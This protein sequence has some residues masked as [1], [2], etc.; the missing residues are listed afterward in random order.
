MIE[1]TFEEAVRLAKNGAVLFE[2]LEEGEHYIPFTDCDHYCDTIERPPDDYIDDV[3]EKMMNNLGY[4]VNDQ[5][6]EEQHRF[7]M[8]TR[9]GVHVEKKVYKL[10]WR[11]Y[12]FGFVIKMSELKKVIV[13]K[14]LDKA[15]VGSLDSSPYNKNQLLGCVGFCKSKKDRRVLKPCGDW[16]LEKF[17]VQNIT[18]DETILTYDDLDQDVEN[19]SVDIDDGNYNSEGSRFAPPWEIL[20]LLVMNLNVELRCEK[21]RYEPWARIGWAIAGVA[22]AAKRYEDGLG[23]WL[24]FCRQC[25]SAYLEDPMKARLV[26]LNAKKQDHQLG[27]SS[28]MAALREDNSTV[29]DEIRG[30]L[31]SGNTWAITDDNQVGVIR[32]FLR[33]KLSCKPNR[34]SSIFI[35]EYEDRKVIVIDTTETYCSIKE[36]EHSDS[37]FPLTYY[38]IASRN[39]KE[40]CRHPECRDKS[41][42]TVSAENYGEALKKVV[43]DLL[44]GD[45]STEKAIQN[46]LQHTF[47]GDKLLQKMNY[48]IGERVVCDFSLDRF[49]LT[50][51]RYCPIHDCYHE[52]PENCLILSKNIQRM[53]I[54]CRQDAFSYYPP[55]GLLVP[56][57]IVNVINRGIIVHNHF[58]T[59]TDAGIDGLFDDLLPIFKDAELNRLMHLSFKGYASDVAQVFYYLGH[60]RFGVQSGESDTWW[61]WDTEEMRWI[62]S[63]HKANLFCDGEL[64][65]KYQFA[66]SWYK[67]NTPDNDIRIRRLKQVDYLLKRLK[68]RDQHSILVQAAIRTRNV[69]SRTGWTVTK[70][71]SIS[72]GRSSILPGWSSEMCALLIMFRRQQD[73]YCPSTVVNGKQ[74]LWT[75]SGRLCQMLLMSSTC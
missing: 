1:L 15:G 30:K 32:D 29:Y 10:S 37:E 60:C 9:H 57:K 62:Q 35:K 48:E 24:W 13:R 27:W 18:G 42:M 47:K 51:N 2:V 46:L 40:K 28:L 65:G 41:G 70:T 25:M 33:T 8:A 64:A 59:G 17:M 56:P 7:G 72:G 73:T 68:D 19:D 75:L 12:F 52:H 11:C 44:S 55:D 36:D 16:P 58:T 22:R 45:I 5:F 3:K 31:A 69:N 66:A 63:S 54:K 21:G 14:R 34:I 61:A 67:N 23:L 20:E 4:L 38:I 50:E 6:D 39:A 43:E 53:G 49:E 26:Y 74:Q 71:L